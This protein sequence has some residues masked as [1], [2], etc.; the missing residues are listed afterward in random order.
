MFLD[1]KYTKLYYTIINKAKIRE[2]ENPLISYTE[3][4]H[5]IPKSLGGTNLTI[6]LVRLKPREHF[7]VHRLLTKMTTGKWLQ[8]AWIALWAMVGPRKGK[9]RD[10]TISSR[11]YEHIRV[12]VSLAKVKDQVG[13][14]YGKITVIKYAGIG[15][16]NSHRW[17]CQCDCGN[18]F[19][20]ARVDKRR[21][22][23]CTQLEQL[24][25]PE[26]RINNMR[27]KLKID[28]TPQTRGSRINAII[29]WAELLRDD[30][31]IPESIDGFSLVN[32]KKYKAKLSETDREFRKIIYDIYPMWSR[33]KK[34][35]RNKTFLTNLVINS[36]P[37]FPKPKKTELPDLSY[38]TTLKKLIKYDKQ[39]KILLMQYQPEWLSNTRDPIFEEITK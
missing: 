38:Y 20:S 26:T 8:K 16:N 32:L 3:R 9:R 13:N 33:D 36:L 18:T 28:W 5:I 34:Q 24:T 11:M 29:K 25:K 7:I 17:E 27:S 6:N 2:I 31:N 23:G 22:C 39:F 4:H 21:S 30:K 15:H 12:N 14:R 1:N 37:N 10:Y 35:E 19:I